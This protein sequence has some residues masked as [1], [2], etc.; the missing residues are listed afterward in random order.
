M[1]FIIDIKT[2]PEHLEQVFRGIEGTA[3]RAKSHTRGFVG[4]VLGT[5][6]QRI[7]V[8]VTPIGNTLRQQFGIV[9]I[10]AGAEYK[11]VAQQ[12]FR[13]AVQV[14]KTAPRRHAH[15]KLP[16]IDG[17]AQGE[18]TVDRARSELQF[19]R[20]ELDSRIAIS[21][22]LSKAPRTLR[23]A[24]FTPGRRGQAHGEYRQRGHHPHHRDQGH[25][26]STA[27]GQAT[28]DCTGRPTGSAPHWARSI[29]VVF[30][31]RPGSAASTGTIRSGQLAPPIRNLKATRPGR[32][33]ASLQLSC[34]SLR[35]RR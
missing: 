23:P 6:R 7:L 32:T 30:T 2:H 10:E 35:P 28:D 25:A 12:S 33:A 3:P 1:N 19:A 26:R 17:V 24:H 15:D 16:A 5:E 18:P 8:R 9:G 27:R 22:G 13:R 34:Q 21:C 4:R 14:H 31:S 29:A 20:G 11:Q